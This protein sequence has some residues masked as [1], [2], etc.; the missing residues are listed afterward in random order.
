MTRASLLIVLACGLIAGGWLHP[1]DADAGRRRGSA[2]SSGSAWIETIDVGGISRSYCVYLPRRYAGRAVVFHFHGGGGDCLRE[3]YTNWQAVA[4]R[5]GVLL[6]L[7]NG[8]DN[9]WNACSAPPE[10]CA[11]PRGSAEDANVDDL[12]FFEALR[13]RIMARF[14]PDRVYV[15]GHSK[16][17][18]MA[19]HIACHLGDLVDAV[20]AVAGT[21]T[22]QTCPGYQVPYLHLH[23]DD[24]RNVPWEGGGILNDWPAVFPGIDEQAALNGC[25]ADWTEADETAEAMSRRFDTCAAET[26]FWL[27]ACRHGW[28][29]ADQPDWMIW[30]V[31]C[32]SSFRAEE[33]LWA[34]YARH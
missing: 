1:S 15:G 10:T 24:D 34:F 6:V 22:S 3:G 2:L 33:V 11:E 8:L 23:G 32:T 16:G 18:M 27:Y 26:V 25:A 9:T 28:P 12:A 31:P 20:S 19:R 17:G 14:A 29:G 21:L 4:D 13:A 7:P 30:A 5:E